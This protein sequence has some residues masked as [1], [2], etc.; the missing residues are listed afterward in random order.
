VRQALP[1]E[2]RHEE[3]KP[4][5]AELFLL[6]PSNRRFFSLQHTYTH[7][8]L[9]AL[10]ASHTA[11]YEDFMMFNLFHYGYNLGEKPYKCVTCLKAFSQSS[12][13]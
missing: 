7:T 5:R 4:Q 11:W 10:E 12:N 9:F 13:L 3:G 6:P 2:K 8:G 1:S